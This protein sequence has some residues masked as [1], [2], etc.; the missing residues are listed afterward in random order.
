MRL[1]PLQ[2]F[3]VLSSLISLLMGCSGDEG[4]TGATASLSWDPGEDHAGVTYTVHYGKNPS[5]EPGSC[6]YEHAV[7]V[8]EPSA[9][10]AGLDFSTQYYFAVSAYN[11]ERSLCSNEVSKLTPEMEFQIGDPPVNVTSPSPRCDEILCALQTHDCR[12]DREDCG[13]ARHSA[14]P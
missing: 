8:S 13:G 1:S 3:F 10:I 11:G 2:S 5:G 4:V 9:M 12:V 6:N 7:D 14:T